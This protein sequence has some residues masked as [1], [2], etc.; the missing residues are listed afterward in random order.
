MNIKRFLTLCFCTVFVFLNTAVPNV[1]AAVLNDTDALVSTESEI[2]SVS[3]FTYKLVPTSAPVR[4]RITGYSGKAKKVVIPEELGGMPVESVAS[5]AFAGN[6]NITHI[7][8]PSTLTTVSGKIFNMCS[9]LESIEIDSSNKNFCTVDGVLYNKEKTELLVFPAGKSGTFTIPYGVETVCAYAFDHCYNLTGINMYNTVTTVAQNAF[10]F[11]WSLED[12]RLSDNLRTLGE[13]ALAHCDSL[14]EIY[15][16]AT[17]TKI[18]DDAVLGDIDSNNCKIYYFTDGIH[19]TPNTYAYAYLIKSGIPKNVIIGE[20]RTVT[21]IDTGITLVDAN[22]VLPIDE[23]ID[24]TVKKVAIEK[25]KE[26]FPIRYEQAYC[27]DI[28]FTSD[29]EPYTPKGNFI[30]LF[31]DVGDG[32]IPS[33]TKVYKFYGSRLINV[34]GTP[35]TPFIGTQSN[36]GGRF[37]I[38]SNNDFSLK[39]DVDGDGEITLYDARATLYAAAGMLEFTGEQF[40]AADVCEPSKNKI[41]TEDARQ[42]LRKAAGLIKDF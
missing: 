1:D 14:T 25:V 32:M 27:F 41:N 39:G 40:A 12:I 11:C 6:E 18:G 2:S 5:V 10:S 34:S 37:V 19:C 42:I 22:S 8:L 29:G 24:I 31:D 13:Q 26:Y 16:P 38:I 17:L 28:S 35:N 15:L 3:D 30:L 23:D 4:A 33:A 21:D 7:K 9:S 36:S 20:Y